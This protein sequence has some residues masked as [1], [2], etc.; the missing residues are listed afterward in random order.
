MTQV[1]LQNETERYLSNGRNILR[2][3]KKQGKFYADS[4][5]TKIAGHT[6]YSAMLL[7]LDEVMPKNKKQRNTEAVYRKFLAEKN[8]KILQHFNNAYYVLHQGMGYDG[9][10]SVKVI[11][12]G[13]DDAKEVINW[14]LKR[15]K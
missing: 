2:K 13:I 12:T 5:Y 1:L 15:K 6:F 7:A 4:K 8:K 9:I 14:C 3:A 10:V 11:N